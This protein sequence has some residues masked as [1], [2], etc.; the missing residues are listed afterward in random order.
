MFVLF[1]KKFYFVITSYHFRISCCVCGSTS[2]F[3]NMLARIIFVSVTGMLEYRFV[4]SNE[5]KVKCG[6]TS[7]S[8][9]FCNRS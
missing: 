1:V 9:R 3:L 7:V 4:I 2:L 6:N 5:A 8:L